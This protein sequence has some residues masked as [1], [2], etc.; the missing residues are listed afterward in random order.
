MKKT[1][2]RKS[3]GTIPLRKSQTQKKFWEFTNLLAQR[4]MSKPKNIQPYHLQL[5]RYSLVRR[6]HYVWRL[7]EGGASL[8]WKP[9]WKNDQWCRFWRH[10]PKKCF[11]AV[12]FN[13]FSLSSPWVTKIITDYLYINTFTEK[14]S[15]LRN[16]QGDGAR[17][18]SPAVK[19]E[20]VMKRLQSAPKL[21]N[22]F[23]HVDLCI[24]YYDRYSSFPVCATFYFLVYPNTMYAPSP[25]RTSPPRISPYEWLSACAP[26]PPYKC[27]IH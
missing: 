25:N 12:I 14:W 15:W 4:R 23:T 9:F 17:N 22:S 7:E 27:Q 3:R 24:Y 8:V 5:G 10:P 16:I 2:G 21:R 20:H 1:R 18:N 19:R 13:C 6:S 11:S 26:P